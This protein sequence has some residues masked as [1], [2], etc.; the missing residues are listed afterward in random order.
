MRA[1]TSCEIRG[2]IVISGL[3]AAALLGGCGFEP[4]PGEPAEAKPAP[5]LSRYIVVLDDSVGPDEVVG[6]ARA[7]VSDLRPGATSLALD[8]LRRRHQD[9]EVEAALYHDFVFRRVFPGFV[10]ALDE[11]DEAALAALRAHP[12]VVSVTPDRE[13]Q[14]TAQSS[15]PGMQRIRVAQNATAAINGVDDVRIDADIAVIDS[16]ID[17]SHPD[18]NVYHSVSLRDDDPSLGDPNGHG[19]HVAGIAAALDNDIGVH[20]VAPGARLWS[21]K[22]I[23]AGGSTTDS[24]I[25]AGLEYALEHADEI[26][27]VNLSLAGFGGEPDDRSCG[28]TSGEPIHL[29]VCGLV[30][31][32]VV[33]VTAAGNGLPFFGDPAPAEMFYPARYDEVI[34]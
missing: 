13:V 32:G 8:K 17:P 27:V 20:G 7:L 34:T 2:S 19:T 5:E 31:S 18:L 10:V 33:V 3:L 26:D 15:E 6:K 4:E 9:V 1:R 22:I 28:R 11:Q 21:I 14:A 24:L 16:G 12:D 25:V 23:D 30:E 29:A